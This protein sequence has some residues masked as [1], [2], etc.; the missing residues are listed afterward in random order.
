MDGH[1]AQHR[2]HFLRVAETPQPEQP[3]PAR[4]DIPGPDP[5]FREAF[6]LPVQPARAEHR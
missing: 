1:T 3:D 4:G 6:P 5:P 2:V